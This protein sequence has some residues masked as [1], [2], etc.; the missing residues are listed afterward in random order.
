MYIQ[1]LIFFLQIRR[2]R[3]KEQFEKDVLNAAWGWKSPSERFDLLRLGIN[4]LNSRIIKKCHSRCN[5]SRSW[6]SSLSLI[7]RPA[8]PT[9][10]RWFWTRRTPS[11]RHLWQ[12]LDKGIGKSVSNKGNVYFWNQI[13]RARFPPSQCT[14]HCSLYIIQSSKSEPNL[15]IS[16]TIKTI[17]CPQFLM[18]QSL[19]STRTRLTARA[20]WPSPK[21][22]WW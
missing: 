19:R 15:V 21:V 14:I 3:V 2:R 18:T 4:V 8:S 10:R 17:L 13:Y 16:L 11:H 20:R 9:R 5:E 7:W 12:V 6:S 1:E 22:I